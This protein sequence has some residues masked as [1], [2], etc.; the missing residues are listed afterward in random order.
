M[1]AKSSVEPKKYEIKGDVIFLRENINSFTTEND[2]RVDEGFEYNE[3]KLTLI[4]RPNL[5]QYIESN[6]D[7]L[8]QF[9]KDKEKANELN[10]LREKRD[11]V[12]K[13]IDKYQLVLYYNEL[14]EVQKQEL[15]QYRAEWLNITE[16]EIVPIKPSWIICNK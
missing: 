16:T 2:G 9:A 15:E 1:K 3:Y 5:T 7:V 6:F 11:T 8:L 4:S 14:T 10:K 13:T 12:F